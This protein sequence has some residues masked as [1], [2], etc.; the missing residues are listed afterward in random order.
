M[1]SIAATI[2]GLVQEGRARG[3]NEF[4]AIRY[5]D[6]RL[7]PSVTISTS[8]VAATASELERRMPGMGQVVWSAML[9]MALGH[10]ILETTVEPGQPRGVAGIPG[11]PGWAW[12]LIAALV[13]LMMLAMGG[14]Q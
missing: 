6:D 7:D 13:G 14:R 2:A 11:I 12:G 3:Y 4:A 8:Q 5:A 9:R 1:A 10:R